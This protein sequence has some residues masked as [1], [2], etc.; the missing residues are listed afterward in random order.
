[1]QAQLH[2]F[3]FGP[4]HELD[5]RSKAQAH[6]QTPG[7]GPGA[8]PTPGSGIE[9]LDITQKLHGRSLG[10]RLR[11][12]ARRQINRGETKNTTQNIEQKTLI[13]RVDGLVGHQRFPFTTDL[14]NRNTYIRRHIHSEIGKIR[15]TLT[16]KWLLTVR[17][18]FSSVAV[19]KKQTNHVFLHK[20]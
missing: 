10:R 4:S 8:G 13:S 6:A 5:L 20:V 14:F 3:E 17:Q 2:H 1:M 18:F 15:S 19:T 7:T 12:L 16:A 9:K 11:S